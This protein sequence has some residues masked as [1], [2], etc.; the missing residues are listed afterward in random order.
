[1]LYSTSPAVLGLDLEPAFF[2]YCLRGVDR[3]IMAAS[4]ENSVASASETV[5]GEGIPSR[6]WRSFSPEPDQP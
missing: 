5:R 3:E 1:M 2:W 4:A 6:F